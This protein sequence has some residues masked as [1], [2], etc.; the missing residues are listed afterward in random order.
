MGFWRQA[1]AHLD[2][3]ALESIVGGK[4]QPHRRGAIRQMIKPYRLSQRHA[5][6]PVGL[7]RDS[8]CYPPQP[9]E[10]NAMLVGQIRQTAWIR[11]RFGYRRILIEPGKPMQ[12]GYKECFNGR[13]RDECLDEQW[14]E[15]LSQARAC[16]AEGVRIFV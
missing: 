15:S 12:N 7:S 16:I 13:F 10:L 6:L 5:C 14:V 2:V 11:R 8:C 9:S 3:H 1:K 4:R